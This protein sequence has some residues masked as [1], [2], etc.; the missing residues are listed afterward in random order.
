MRLHLRLAL[1]SCFVALLATGLTGALLISEARRE[2]AAQLLQRQQLLAQNRAF[3]L[4]DSLEVALR[5]LVRL[6]NMA[7]VDLSDDDLRPE[8]QLLAHAHRNSTL[9]NIGLRIHDAS[10][11]CLWAEPDSQ[12]CKDETAADAPWFLEGMKARGAIVVAEGAPSHRIDILVPIAGKHSARGAVVGVLRGIIDPRTD[13]IIAPALSDA[14][15]AGTEAAVVAARGGRLIYPASLPRS[16]GWDRALAGAPGAAGAF[17]IEED[18]ER[19]LFAHAPV[20][21]AGWGLAFRWRWSQL[22]DSLVR[23][24]KLLWQ[25]LAAGGVLAVLLSLASSRWQVRPLEQL[26]HERT[27]ELEAAQRALLAQERL[28]A[29][30][31]AAAVISHELKNSLGALGMGVELI[32]RD[33]GAAGLAKVHGQVREEVTRLRTLTDELLVFAR[34][35]QVEKQEQDLNL[36]LQRAADLSAEQA[37]S[38]GVRVDLQLAPGPLT[39]S[40]DGRRIQSVLVNLVI[41]AIEAVA[42]QKGRP[43]PAADQATEQGTINKGAVRLTTA[44]TPGAVQVTVEDSGPGLSAEAQGHLFEPFFTTKRNGTGLGLSTSQRFIGAHGGRIES[45][46]SDLGGA[47]FVVVLPVGS[48]AGGKA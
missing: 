18:G 10:G 2:G 1:V 43:E 26:V 34:S 32:A 7:E 15:P 35:P 46:K 25:I 16:T 17:S 33:A 39:V 31:Q 48:Q 47:R 23:Q 40:C 22:D 41:N 37:A 11:R 30:G 44:A 8:A 14:L 12:P 21:H 24:R 42:F 19:W 9:F 27:A 4:G 38:S 29:M 20:A 28:A 36:L 3:A 6:S 5:E 13:R 45:G